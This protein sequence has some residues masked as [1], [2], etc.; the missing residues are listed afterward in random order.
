MSVDVAAAGERRLLGC[1]TRRQTVTQ[2]DRRTDG[3]TRIDSGQTPDGE[4]H[5]SNFERLFRQPASQS[6]KT[7][8]AAGA[9]Q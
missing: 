1:R 8:C 3:R 5:I 9:K 7:R 2:T 4:T 6:A